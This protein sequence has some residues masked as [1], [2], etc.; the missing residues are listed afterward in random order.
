LPP[1]RGYRDDETNM[2][3]VFR[4]LSLE[5]QPGWV[6]IGYISM[7]RICIPGRVIAMR[8]LCIG[9]GLELLRAT[10]RKHTDADADAEGLVDKR[11]GRQGGLGLRP[12]ASARR[13]QGQRGT[14]SVQIQGL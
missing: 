4:Q 6:K 14:Y 5:L 2:N 8:S 10:T 1:V 3:D 9:T 7:E 11:L 12:W 13:I